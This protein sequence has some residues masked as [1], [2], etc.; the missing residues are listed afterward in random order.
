VRILLFGEVRLG[1]GGRLSD[2][3]SRLLGRLALDAGR[4]VS[5]SALCADLWP[6]PVPPNR[7]NVALAALRRELGQ[8]TWLQADRRGV[9][10][11]SPPV[12]T[13]LAESLDAAR[14][15]WIEPARRARAFTAAF[16]LA[17]GRLLGEWE[18]GWAVMA[19]ARLAAVLGEAAEWALANGVPCGRWR[20]EAWWPA[21]ATFVPARA[22][23]VLVAALGLPAEWWPRALAIHRGW[24][25][26]DEPVGRFWAPEDA[27]D[28][29]RGAAGSD[30]PGRAL[31]HVAAVPTFG[32][33]GSALAARAA[34]LAPGALAWTSAARTVVGQ[35]GMARAEGLEPPTPSSED[36]CSIR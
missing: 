22:V 18:D 13:D 24:R 33:A 9:W 8:P 10:V 5:R 25:V 27:V 23:L 20:H 26:G 3:S 6:G 31:V 36:W 7:L 35:R 14:Q 11:E 34:R 30:P 32:E 4:R 16:D 21:P 15:G 17:N 2:S 1:A 29:A 28:F 19:R 12:T